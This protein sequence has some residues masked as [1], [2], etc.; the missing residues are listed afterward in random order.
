VRFRS[1]FLR[2]SRIGWFPL[3]IILSDTAKKQPGIAIKERNSRAPGSRNGTLMS[4]M[5]C[6]VPLSTARLAKSS[7]PN[8]LTSKSRAAP[9][10]R[11]TPINGR[12]NS[13]IISLLYLSRR[14]NPPSIW[15]ISLGLRRVSAFLPT[16]G[17]KSGEDWL[18]LDARNR[19]AKWRHGGV[20]Q[21]ESLYQGYWL[22]SVVLSL[23]VLISVNTRFRCSF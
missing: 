4:L 17:A 5:A 16:G 18:V 1:T 7:S 12:G 13:P 9:T 6:Q 23:V 22:V 19:L 8:K 20:S 14:R 21:I 15:R 10:A 2:N 3:I 11:L